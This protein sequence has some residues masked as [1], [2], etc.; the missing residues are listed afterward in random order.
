MKQTLKY[1]LATLNENLRFAEA[2]AVSKTA[3]VPKVWS[4]D[5]T[6]VIPPPRYSVLKAEFSIPLHLNK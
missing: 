2:K 5:T 3:S 6:A 1:I 4:S